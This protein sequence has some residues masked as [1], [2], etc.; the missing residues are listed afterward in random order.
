MSKATVL[1]A[2]EASLL[3][4][5][6]AALCE[7]TGA[8][9]VIAQCQD[10]EEALRLLD[11]LRPD[12]AVLDL[13]LSG[14]YAIELV[15]KCRQR[16]IPTRLVLLAHRQDRKTVVEGLR[17]G[18]NAFVLKSGPAAHF[19]EALDQVMK[20]GI[21]IS[22][23]VQLEQVFSPRV[24]NGVEDPVGMLSARE[25]QV[26][27]MLI[28]G[29]R[30]KEI[31]ARLDLSPKTVDTYRASPHAQTRHPRRRR[32]GQ[33]RHCAKPHQHPP[34]DAITPLVAHP[35]LNSPQAA[36]GGHAA[37]ALLPRHPRP[38]RPQAVRPASRQP[39]ASPHSAAL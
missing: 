35:T 27:S 8:Y 28:E 37:P 26:F 10:G 33:V 19:L 21:Y 12:I 2:D 17:C 13:N 14:L 30:A 22:P 18:A 11:K 5:G 32:A 1:L 39:L 7:R 3:R 29:V 4:E 6:L 31:A 34:K 20:G 16:D 24:N 23:H 15:S 9:D 38:C 25:Y 36:P